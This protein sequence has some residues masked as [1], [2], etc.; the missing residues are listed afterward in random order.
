M[1][2]YFQDLKE[3]IHLLNVSLTNFEA[4]QRG[5]LLKYLVRELP[6]E[7]EPNGS[8]ETPQRDPALDEIEIL[9]DEDPGDYDEERM[10]RSKGSIL[11]QSDWTED[12]VVGRIYGTELPDDA[13]IHTG[14][15]QGGWHRRQRRHIRFRT[16]N[17]RCVSV[18]HITLPNYNQ[19]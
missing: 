15:V 5:S 11:D 19:I 18:Q 14:L 7:T 9:D 1:F 8:G 3:P 4:Q 2:V 16:S 17:L 13:S 6:I 10:D 12:A